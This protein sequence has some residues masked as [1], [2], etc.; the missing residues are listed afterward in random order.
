M[1]ATL[2]TREKARGE[3]LKEMSEV[4]GKLKEINKRTR[5]IY[6]QKKVIQ[7]KLKAVNDDRQ[8][9]DEKIREA[10]K[11]LGLK[12]VLETLEGNLSAIDAEIQDI[13]SKMETSTLGIKVE[14]EL[15]A[16]I[17]SLNRKKEEV[18]LICLR[19]RS[20]SFLKFLIFFF[21]CSDSCILCDERRD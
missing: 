15:V 4:K 21:S 3:V 9:R 13:D 2:K 12:R 5:K 14:K 18:I 7:N 1:I 8:A 20:M 17:Q 11:A 10:K 6:D 19:E 16:K